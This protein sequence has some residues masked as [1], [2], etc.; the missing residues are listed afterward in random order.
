MRWPKVWKPAHALKV[1]DVI[2]DL[3]NKTYDRKILEVSFVDAGNTAQ[4][5]VQLIRSGNIRTDHYQRNELLPV[6]LK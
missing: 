3:Q 4:L 2:V 6:G 1:G 5:K